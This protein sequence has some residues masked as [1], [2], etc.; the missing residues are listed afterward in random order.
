[1]TPRQTLSHVVDRAI[2]RGAAVIEE[3]PAPHVVRFLE[4]YE[5]AQNGVKWWNNPHPS[6]SVESYDWDKGHTRFRT[7][8]PRVLVKTDP[9]YPEQV[10]QI[11]DFNARLRGE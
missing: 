11:E 2:A 9:A 1:M 8:M 4:G 6:G 3:Q 10:R 7:H 5:A